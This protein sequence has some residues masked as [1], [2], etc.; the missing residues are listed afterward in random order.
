VI[1]TKYLKIIIPTS[2][3]LRL[4]K[5][6]DKVRCWLSYQSDF[7]RFWHYSHTEEGGGK[8][9]LAAKILAASHIIERSFSLPHIRLG[10]GEEKI[11]AMIGM[12]SRYEELGYNIDAMAYTN[13]LDVLRE[14][15]QYHKDKEYDLGTFGDDIQQVLPDSEKGAG[16]LTVTATD[17][18]EKARGDFRSCALSR[19]SVRTYGSKPVSE[20]KIR[21][22]MEIARKTPSVCN[23][24]SWN[25]Y[26]IKSDDAKAKLINLQNGLSGFG[27]QVDSFLI[28]TT[29]LCTFL[30]G[31]E[32]NQAFVDGGLYAMSLLY[33]LHYVGLGACP[34]NWCMPPKSDQKLR[35]A[36]DIGRN[37]NIIVVIAIGS[38]PDEV[39][40]SKSVR[41]SVSDTINIR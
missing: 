5:Q 28:V 31:G 13:S 9:A 32:R 21:E 18:T 19:Y 8:N 35:D 10:F 36:L 15:F 34:C 16:Y 30:K 39:R 41:K 1:L 29:D 20:E 7:K 2:F 37:E 22:S 33:A 3:Y 6:R 27:H 12:L 38:L 40:V 25:A 24:Q 11:R 23:R 14:Y 17:L 4:K 26:W